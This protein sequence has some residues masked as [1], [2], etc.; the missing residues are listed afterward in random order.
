[1]DSVALVGLGPPSVR[2]V[3]VSLFFAAPQKLG[4]CCP[5]LVAILSDVV[6]CEDWGAREVRKY[7]HGKGSSDE[8]S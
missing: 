4:S 6:D 5:G 3:G 2:M 7:S 1:V 8:A